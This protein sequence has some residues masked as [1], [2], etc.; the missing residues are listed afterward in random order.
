MNQE[1]TKQLCIT[2]KCIKPPK[3]RGLCTSCY[4]TAAGLVKGN[5]VTW[6]K[7]ENLKKCLPSKRGSKKEWFLEG[8]EDAN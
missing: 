7:L 8:V 2:K 6:E 5:K 3:V 4:A 1:N